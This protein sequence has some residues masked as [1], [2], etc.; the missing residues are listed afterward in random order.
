MNETVLTLLTAITFYGL[1]SLALP[2]ASNDVLNEP[3]DAVSEDIASTGDPEA[4]E[5]RQQVG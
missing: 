2:Q 1:S 4:V 5:E 3:D